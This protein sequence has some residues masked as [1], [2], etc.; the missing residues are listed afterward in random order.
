MS[1]WQ[2]ARRNLLHQ[3][4]RFTVSV[5]GVGF[6]IVLMYMQLGF[7]GAVGDAAT[8]VY[9]RTRFDLVV[10]SPEYLHVFDARSVPEGVVKLMRSADDVFAVTPLDVTVA[11]WRNPQTG[12][13][14]PVAM[15]GVDPSDIA[16][17]LSEVRDQASQLRGAA[18]VLVDRQTRSDY[19]PADSL[20]FSTDDVGRRVEISGQGTRIAGLFS[21]GTGLAANGAVC[22]SRDQFRQLSPVPHA[23]RVSIVLIK[24]VAG[25]DPDQVAVRCRQQL[26]DV[27]G[28]SAHAV[29]MT[30]SR[31]IA[32]ERRRWYLET[33]VGII[34]AAGVALAVI[35]GAVI[36]SM[37]LGADV[38][39]H[40]P[41]YATLKAMGYGNGFLMKTLLSQALMLA[42]AALVPATLLAWGLF[43]LT[44]Q[45]SGVPIRMTGQWIG[46]VSLLT[47]VMCSVAGGV[48]IRKL[49][50]A[51]P[52]SLF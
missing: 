33:P 44:T 2:L 7:L 31:V 32:A 48:A 38:L 45:Y 21:M 18:S 37:V 15:I 14:R 20:A 5:A 49:A 41:E 51:E 4:V 50:K 43:V 16:I 29:V 26:R 47:F 3:R 6:A 25:V 36:C 52:A 10:R 24:L 42:V 28:E 8:I 27:G 22:V 40:L 35:V 39:S 1:G 17:D 11:D 30:R 19:G 9:D 13:F 12:E 23:G 46:L 34:F